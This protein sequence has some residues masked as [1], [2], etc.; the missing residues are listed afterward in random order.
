MRLHGDGDG[1]LASRGRGDRQRHRGVDRQRRLELQHEAFALGGELGQ[2]AGELRGDLGVDALA[3]AEHQRVKAGARQLHRRQRRID[4]G[5][6]AADQLEQSSGDIG[7]AATMQ[8]VGL[9]GVNFSGSECV[10]RPP[11]PALRAD[12]SPK[13][14]VVHRHDPATAHLSLGG[15]VGRRPGEGAL[16]TRS[17][18]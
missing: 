12:L 18:Q 17:R 6:G 9:T 11:H 3:E 7:H 13:G 4:G 15:E 1:R 2:A 10:A 5:L 8:G 14:E 16:P